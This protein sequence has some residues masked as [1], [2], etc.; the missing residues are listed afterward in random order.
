MIA[1][2]DM[3]L[4][5]L[6]NGCS[7][8]SPT[9]AGQRKGWPTF[10]VLYYPMLLMR[11][12]KDTHHQQVNHAVANVVSPSHKVKRGNICS[13]PGGRETCPP[14]KFQESGRQKAMRR[15]PAVYRFPA[16]EGQ[17]GCQSSDVV[18]CAATGV[19]MC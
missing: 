11:R 3:L 1:V 13:C 6:A 14:S 8:P 17:G 18:V 5:L 16:S 15:A 9:G 12:Y 10:P 19:S 4:L 7:N 2:M